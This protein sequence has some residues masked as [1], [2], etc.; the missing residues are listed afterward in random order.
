MS[1]CQCVDA[2]MRQRIPSRFGQPLGFSRSRLMSKHSNV[3]M[4]EHLSFPKLNRSEDRTFQRPTWAFEHSKF[5]IL[6]FP[7]WRSNIEMLNGSTQLILRMFRTITTKC[8]WRL[9]AV[10]CSWRKQPR[11]TALTTTDS[12][13]SEQ[14][15]EAAFSKEFG[16]TR[17]RIYQ[18]CFSRDL[19][20]T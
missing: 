4:F 8:I 1:T 6:H 5:R 9:R 15:L 11:Q 7:A 16:S 13:N 3:Q 18:R 10:N 20:A 2:S 19:R 17:T 14:T 12:K